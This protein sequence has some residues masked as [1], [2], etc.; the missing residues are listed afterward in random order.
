[1]PQQIV[2]FITDGLS[3]LY[4]DLDEVSNIAGV[5]IT[6]LHGVQNRMQVMFKGGG[7]IY[8]N[9]TFVKDMEAYMD[10]WMKHINSKVA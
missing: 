1:M 5:E 10:A 4:I 9:H 7:T 8:L 6:N 2:K 3:P